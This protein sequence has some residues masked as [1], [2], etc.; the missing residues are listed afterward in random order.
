[1]ALKSWVPIPPESHFSLANL[2]FGVITSP[3]SKIPHAA[4]AV[5]NSAL[6]LA[7]F[8][9][10]DGFS[11]LPSIH[12]HLSVFS[13]ST[14]NDFAALGRS[15][16]RQVRHYLQEVLAENTSFPSVLRDNERLR[17]QC[18]YQLTEVTNH[19]PLHIGDYTDFYVGKHHAVNVGK[20]FAGQGNFLPPNYTHL[21]VGYHGRASS[22]VISGTPIRRPWGQILEEPAA[23]SKVPV[24]A[25]SRRLDFEVELGAFVCRTNDMGQPVPIDE[26]DESL[27]GLVLLNDWSARDI[28]FW[29]CVP[30]GPFGSKNFGT[31]ISP[32]VVLADALEPFMTKALANDTTVLPYLQEKR[33]DNVYDIKLEAELTSMSPYS[34]FSHWNLT[35]NAA[36]SDQTTTIVQTNSRNLLFSFPQMLAHHSITGCPMN[37]GDLLGSGTIS[38][39]EEGA[40]GCLLERS[41]NGNEEIRLDGGETR[42]FLEDH[43]TVTIRGWVGDEGGLVGFGECVGKI[44]PAIKWG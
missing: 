33:A 5:G 30:L 8:V 41:K 44:Q 12:P 42:K 26:A 37:V 38:G 19:L 2:P 28:Q 39:P 27:F 20:M 35:S 43:D 21:P 18:F 25:P 24:L 7:V 15:M 3:Q 4:I 13:K 10:N 1:M 22:V 6:D 32:W 17:A 31:S 23:A 16:H 34:H 9:A 14:L 40:Q 11:E 29:E 36:K